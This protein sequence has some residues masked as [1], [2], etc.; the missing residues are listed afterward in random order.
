MDVDFSTTNNYGEMQMGGAGF[1][2]STTPMFPSTASPT[3]HSQP[4]FVPNNNN[5]V[6]PQQQ[7]HHQQQTAGPLISSP[8]NILTNN[9]NPLF[10]MFASG[11][12]LRT[13]FVPSDPSGTKFTMSLTS[14]G[15]LPSPLTAVNELAFFLLPSASAVLPPNMG[16]MIY[17]QLQILNGGPSSGFELL[18]ALIPSTNPSGIFRTGWADHEQ[19]VPLLPNQ[20]VQINIGISV[21]PLET[22]KNVEASNYLA[23]RQQQSNHTTALL[24]QKIGQD[25]FNFMSSFDTNGAVGNQTI[26][27]PANTFDRWWQRLERK[28]QKD[29]DMFLKKN[30]Q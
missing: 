5:N 23:N 13:D 17:W 1:S 16:I 14:P 3:P 20:P 6:T 21:E 8:N 2:F 4:G 11:A 30:L 7:Q 9:N 26:A 28:L 27:V 24:A 22:V 12:P 19:F 29:P 10:G 15:D 18:G 25:L